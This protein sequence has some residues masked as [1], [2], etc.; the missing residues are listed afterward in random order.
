MD[1]KKRV[2]IF[3]LHLGFGGVEQYISSLCK[4]LEDDYKIEIIS[5]YKV[6]EKPAFSF[7]DKVKIT[8]LMNTGPNREEIKMS[9]KK[10]NILKLFIELLKSIKIL[11]LRRTLNIK[12]IKKLDTDYVITTRFHSLLVGKYLKCNAIKIATEHNYHD[13]NKK[14]IKS[15][16]NSVK[17]FDYLV[18][19]SNTLKEFY[20]NKI[21]NTKCIYIPNVIDDIPNSKSKLNNN[22]LIS[23]GRF[24]PEKGFLDLID[25]IEIVK[26]SIFDVKLY[27]VGNGAMLSQLQVKVKEKKLEK[28]IIFTGF[29]NKKEMEEYL[30]K[31]S[32]FVMTSYTESF[33]L[34][35]IEAMSYGLPT[36]ALDSADGPKELLKNNIG[37]L[38]P[39]RD[40]KKMANEIVKLLNDR[41]KAE[42]IS[43]N[44]YK[45]CQQFLINNVK[46]KWLAIVK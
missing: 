39:N 27:L 12:A 33:G 1:N 10:K 42:L 7:S 30:L 14:Y 3:A 43:N 24:S 15:I 34:V 18:C 13:D 2:T 16:V 29:L 25:V 5:T 40:K 9:L 32:I 17:G 31:S 44:G 26:R 35:L 22:N 36:V 46:K 41:R 11:Y 28:N 8:Y 37:I 6:M 45:F 21:G 19:V 20:Q 38:V 4:M 23:I